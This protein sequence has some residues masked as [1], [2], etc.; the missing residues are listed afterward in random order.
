[1]HAAAVKMQNHLSLR[2]SVPQTPPSDQG[3][4]A[5][6]GLGFICVRVSQTRSRR[7]E[8]QVAYLAL[9]VGERDVDE[10]AGVE[11]A[12][13]GAALGRL[14]LLLGLDLL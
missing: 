6:P 7:K 5:A 1:M 12:L 11:L 2:D 13:V 10:A 3:I 8:R 14:L 9:S 4:H